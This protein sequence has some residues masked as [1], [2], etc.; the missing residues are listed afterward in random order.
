[1]NSDKRRTGDKFLNVPST[2]IFNMQLVKMTI[3]PFF[4]LLPVFLWSSSRCVHASREWL[5]SH[6][7]ESLLDSK[8]L[9][10]IFR[11]QNLS[12]HLENRNEDWESQ[13]RDSVSLHL[14]KTCSVENFWV[15]WITGNCF[16]R[17]RTSRLTVR[18]RRLKLMMSLRGIDALEIAEMRDGHYISIYN[19]D[20]HAQITTISFLI[21]RPPWSDRL[22]WRL[23]SRPMNCV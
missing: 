21:I 19:A 6:F 8:N 9:R 22:T 14:P 23:M 1:M 12:S 2:R 5:R 7:G 10:Q 13:L 17:R 16:N 18:R 20:L 4:S 15:F 11:L 3:F